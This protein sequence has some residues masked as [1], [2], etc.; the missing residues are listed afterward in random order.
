MGPS[1]GVVDS[2]SGGGC[3]KDCVGACAGGSNG[4]SL[5]D[6]GSCDMGFAAGIIG[7]EGP[8]RGDSAGV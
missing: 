4:I 5:G 2:G 3:G 7:T 1:F 6:G 8:R